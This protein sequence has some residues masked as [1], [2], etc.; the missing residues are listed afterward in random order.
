MLPRQCV[1]FSLFACGVI[2][3]SSKQEKAL[4]NMHEQPLL[5]KLGFSTKC[6]RKSLHNRKGALRIG[7]IRP[8]NIL[9]L[10]QLKLFVGN[11]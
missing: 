5:I 8:R 6:P 7:L 9:A 3:L 4:M 2:D 11:K 1:N 10:M